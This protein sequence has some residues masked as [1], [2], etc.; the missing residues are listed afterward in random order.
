MLWQAFFRKNFAAG[1][2]AGSCLSRR[3]TAPAAG[4]VAGTEEH[5][6]LA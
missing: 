1:W 4:P 5:H 3:R 6:R 2:I